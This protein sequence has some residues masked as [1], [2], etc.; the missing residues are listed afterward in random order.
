MTDK[1]IIERLGGVGAISS[2][3]GWNYTTVHNWLH[4]G[5]PYKI[6]VLH[7]EYFMNENP[8][9]LNI[10]TEQET[11]HETQQPNHRTSA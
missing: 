3:F 8:T 10:A 2:F 5:I 7:K 1:E 6:K 9:R 4:R 11:H